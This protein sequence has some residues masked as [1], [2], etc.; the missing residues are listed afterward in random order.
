MFMK[1]GKGAPR[2]GGGGILAFAE[3]EKRR[4]ALGFS[5]DALCADA[6]ISPRGYYN[7]LNGAVSPRRLTRS[8]LTKAL[9]RL[10]K[11]AMA[12]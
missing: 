11:E 12:P 5:I 8:K 3:I 4:L 6:G 1:N 9:G 2:P 10:A 7:G